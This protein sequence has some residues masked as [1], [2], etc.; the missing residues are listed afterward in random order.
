MSAA[1]GDAAHAANG[2]GLVA[3]PTKLLLLLL[4]AG[5]NCAVNLAAAAAE[6]CGLAV[7]EVVLRL[8]LPVTDGSS[9]STAGICVAW[10]L[11]P[12]KFAG[13]AC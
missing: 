12:S 9:G 3:V 8:L 2:L 4:L 1:A 11:G 5:F 7:D 10:L 6:P 13:T